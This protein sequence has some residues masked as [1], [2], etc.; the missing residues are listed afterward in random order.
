MP[1]YMQLA[2][3]E[4]NTANLY[5]SEEDGTYVYIHPIDETVVEFIGPGREEKAISVAELFNGWI[6]E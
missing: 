4:T 1:L 2:L 5:Y 6:T 3:K